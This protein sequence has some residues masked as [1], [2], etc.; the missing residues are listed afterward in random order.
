MSRKKKA[1]APVPASTPENEVLPAAEAVRDAAVESVPESTPVVELAAEEAVC[2]AEEAVAA[3]AVAAEVVE[4]VEIAEEEEEEADLGDETSDE[5]AFTEEEEDEDDSGLFDEDDDADEDVDS[6]ENEDSDGDDEDGDAEEESGEEDEEP[7]EDESEPEAEPRTPAKLDR[8]QKILAQAGVASRRAAEEMIE[9]GRVQ[10]NG[11]VVTTLG[12][13]ADAAR[14]HIRVDGKLLQ[15]AERLRYYMLNKPKGYVTTVRDPEGRPTV[16]QFFEKMKERLYPVGR[17]DYLSEG[18]LLV[19]NDGELAHKLTRAA[20]GVEKTYLVKVA[21]QPSEEELD[22]LR[23]GVSIPH[24]KAGEGRVRTSPAKVRQVRLGDN[25]WFEVILI[26]GRNRELRKMFE[27]I[28]HFVEK[29]RRVGYGPLVLDLEPGLM[30]ELDENEL[31]RLRLCAEGKLRKSKA[32]LAA[33]PL[34]KQMPTVRPMGNRPVAERPPFR[35]PAPRDDFRPQRQEDRPYRSEGYRPR[36]AGDQEPRPGADRERRPGQFGPS[37]FAGRPGGS[38]FGDRP[39]GRPEG[40]FEGRPPA[41]PAWQR[42]EGDRPAR[43]ERPEGSFERGPSRPADRPF[44]RPGPG[45]S[46]G[47]RPPAGRG[48]GDKPERQGWSKPGNDDRPAFKRPAAPRR[49]EFDDEDEAP[50]KPSR[51]SIEP[52]QGPRENRPFPT[53]RPGG[54][55]GPRPYVARPSAPRSGSQGDRPYTPRPSGD[56]PRSDRP[57]GFSPR[58]PRPGSDRPYR[59]DDRRERPADQDAGREFRGGEGRGAG[60]PAGKPFRNESGLERRF[61]TS[62]GIPRAGGAR[63]SSKPG[64]G[65]GSRPYG[66]KS[67][68]PGKPSFRRNEGEGASR[69]DSARPFTPRGE[70]EFRPRGPRPPAGSFALRGEKKPDWKPRPAGGGDREGKRPA[71]R[72]GAQSSGRSRSGGFSKPGGFKSGPSGSRPSGKR[73]GGGFGGKKRG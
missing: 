40:R 70:G 51:L 17:L 7:S 22:Q 62:S 48:F 19:T 71:N 44:N 9:A 18:L 59:A 39:A 27:E 6:D 12:S 24:G 35:R 21:G 25:P 16:M 13:K 32:S 1:E 54:P 11:K 55:S 10:V 72:G 60:R 30:R 63:P 61:T 67:D 20:S 5:E 33:Q 65:S 37:K 68:R 3:E 41:R 34:E 47:N 45:K 4:D 31:N 46:F 38:R 42:P 73:P 69:S 53:N 2:V 8:L 52:V 57:G 66:A 43:V 29:I 15:G 14:D 49:E 36:P 58:P 26:E 56:R 50:R 64:K 28:G 23:A